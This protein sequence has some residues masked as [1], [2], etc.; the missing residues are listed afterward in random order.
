MTGGVGTATRQDARRPWRE[1][2]LVAL[3]FETTTADPRRAEPLSVGWVG[4]RGG[5][6]VCG[7]AG[8]T[9]VRHPGEVPVPS[10][11]VH[12]LLPGQLLDGLDPAEL[13]AW[14]DDAVDGRVLV[15]HGAALERSLLDRHDVGYAAV[16][17]T[18]AI[19]RAVDAR[20]GRSHADPRLPAATLRYGVPPLPAH[21]AFRDA[22]GSALLL[23]SLAGTLE[24]ERGEITLEDLL[25]LSR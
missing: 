18:L 23:L 1:V 21:H 9:L 2:D 6:V 14:L 24:Q 8:Y 11:R 19:V 17:D 15:A 16:L 22:L 7:D 12:G 25:L 5:L 20:A 13:G 10:M 3:D 4:I